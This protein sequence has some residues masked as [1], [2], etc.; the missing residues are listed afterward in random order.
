MIETLNDPILS[1]LIPSLIIFGCI[2]FKETVVFSK[3]IPIFLFVSSMILWTLLPSYRWAVPVFVIYSLIILIGVERNVM[4]EV[5]VDNFLFNFKIKG[6]VRIITFG[7]ALAITIFF[8]WF[9]LSN[10][11]TYIEAGS[12]IKILI[13]LLYMSLLIWNFIYYTLVLFLEHYINPLKVL[14]KQKKI[15]GIRDFFVVYGRRN[16]SRGKFF[17]GY[18]IRFENDEKYYFVKKKIFLN[19]VKN[20]DAIYEYDILTGLFGLN[21]VRQVPKMIYRIKVDSNTKNTMKYYSELG[22]WRKRQTIAIAEMCF[23]LNMLL[24]SLFIMFALFVGYTNGKIDTNNNLIL[25]YCILSLTS[26]IAGFILLIKGINDHKKIPKIKVNR[27]YTHFF[28]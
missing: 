20:L 13:A 11:Y 12:E 22:D 6:K 26:F 18:C 5:H 27:V 3:R 1:V 17:Y 2:I 4:L 21:F 28:K 25:T 7:V 15:G 8:I 23:G 16:I 14:K 10:K 9:L 24:L 19:F